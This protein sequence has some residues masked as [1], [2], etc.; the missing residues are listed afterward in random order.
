MISAGRA[1][2]ADWPAL[3]R[4]GL[5]SLASVLCLLAASGCSSVSR[6]E[7]GRTVVEVKATTLPARI[8]S[9][10]FVI[11]SRQ[12]D[13]QVCRFLLDTGSTVS[14]VTPALAGTT[15]F[16]GLGL[17]GAPAIIAGVTGFAVAF[18]IRAGAILWGWALPGFGGP[19]PEAD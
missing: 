10:F 14:Y 16:V 11:E 13:G 12:D 8:I 18:L 19:M 5:C 3:R 4:I 1:R 9:N 6:R 15:T 2:I 7:P 17:L